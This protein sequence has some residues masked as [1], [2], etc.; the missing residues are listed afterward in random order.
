MYVDIDRIVTEAKTGPVLGKTKVG[1]MIQIV[2]EV[3]NRYTLALWSHSL[4]SQFEV[5]NGLK[6]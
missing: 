6:F 1:S 4:K 5:L 2:V 3:I